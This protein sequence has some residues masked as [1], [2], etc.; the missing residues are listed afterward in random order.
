MIKM[1]RFKDINEEMERDEAF[2]CLCYYLINR[3]EKIRKISNDLLDRCD[4][5]NTKKY[6]DQ[7]FFSW[8][9]RNFLGALF[10]QP[11]YLNTAMRDIEDYSRNHKK[12]LNYCKKLAK[13]T[14][15]EAKRAYRWS[16]RILNSYY[17]LIEEY[18]EIK[19]NEM[20]EMGTGENKLSGKYL[21]YKGGLENWI[22]VA[23]KKAKKL[24]QK[25]SKKS[26]KS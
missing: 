26:K 7:G 21:K 22:I 12:D 5:I 9:T 19:K 17:S 16:Y 15:E 10:T 20:S 2:K 4:R 18:P 24:N 6:D 3:K 23:E 1:V 13:D 11:T 25:K 8:R 14:W